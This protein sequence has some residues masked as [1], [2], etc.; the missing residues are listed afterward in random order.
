MTC[1]TRRLLDAE[2]HSAAQHLQARI[3]QNDTGSEASAL[4]ELKRM[5][6]D[7]LNALEKLRVH[8]GEHN[9]S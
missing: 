3:K 1:N 8:E 5:A 4:S 9:C 6:E 2:V 7:L